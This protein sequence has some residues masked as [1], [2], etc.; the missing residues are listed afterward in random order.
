MLCRTV[1]ACRSS[2]GKRSRSLLA[3]PAAP[4][5]AA[6]AAPAA[7]A[8]GAAARSAAACRLRLS[9]CRRHCRCSVLAARVPALGLLLL[10][11]LVLLLLAL[12][13]LLLLRLRLLPLLLLI[14]GARRGG[15]FRQSPTTCSL[16]LCRPA[17]RKLTRQ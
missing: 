5:P 1:G 13:A 11:L 14:C 3:A 17:T 6:P 9:C 10:L 4:A 15:V 2:R 8:L 16:R 7:A 12:L